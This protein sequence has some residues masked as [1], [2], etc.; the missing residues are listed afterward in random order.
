MSDALTMYST[1][2]CGYCK[3]LKIQM[4]NEG[5]PFVEVNIDEDA[6][7]AEFVVQVNRGNATVP[8]VHFPDGAVLTNPTMAQIRAQ[9]AGARPAP[10]SSLY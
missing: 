7:A 2:W 6:E 1:P 5:I 4:Q 9:L 3:R 8:T 10:S